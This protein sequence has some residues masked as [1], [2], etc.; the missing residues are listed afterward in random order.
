MDR[1]KKAIIAILPKLLLRAMAYRF[2]RYTGAKVLPQALSIEIT[3]RCIARCVMC[4]IWK[5]KVQDIGIE[6]WLELLG[7]SSLRRLKE[8]DITGGEPFLREDLSLL[9]LH[10][11]ELK[12][13]HL[14]QLSSV[15]LTTNGFLTER[16]VPFVQKIIGK[17]EEKGLELI[18]VFSMDGRKKIHER[19]RNFNGGFERLIETIEETKKLRKF[20]KNLII[21]I[22][23][24]ILPINLSEL[25]YIE[26]FATKN[27]LFTIISPFIITEMRYGNP[28]F[29]MRFSEKEIEELKRFYEKGGMK[30]EF[31]RK[32]ILD[33]LEKGEIDK[34]CSAGF[35]YFFIKSNGE[36]Y[37]CP[38]INFSLGNFLHTPFSVLLR[39]KTLKTFKK[40][41][42]KMD[43]CKKCTEPGLERYAL[44]FEG[45]KYL[46]FILKEKGDFLEFHRH[47]GLQKYL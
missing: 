36:V 10:L 26:E 4:N 20:H 40:K 43:I 31:H 33:L 27:D 8:L 16:I 41:V 7:S 29:G 19:I 30:W 34:P 17:M 14:N 46:R 5:D 39:S 21:G 12:D 25:P 24:T 1:Y 42:G 37:P 6:K 18:L 3:R 35:N 38:L 15:A 44:P 47:M 32:A 28:D 23:T 2:Y 9:F 13:L 11:L 45:F 22:K